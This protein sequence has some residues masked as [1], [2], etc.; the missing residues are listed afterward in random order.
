MAGGWEPSLA[1]Y[2]VIASIV[3]GTDRATIEALPRITLADSAL[4]APF[5]SFGGVDAHPDLVERAAVLIEH[6]AGNHPLPDGNKRAAF[7]TMARYLD[8]NG[9]RWG[10]PDVAVD[11]GIVERIAAGETSTGEIISWIRARTHPAG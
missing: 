4:A 8:A 1:D 5:A 9:L 2:V 7:L 6:L 10:D 11:A 3:L